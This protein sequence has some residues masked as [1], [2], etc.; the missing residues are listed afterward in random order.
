MRI[1]I[2]VDGSVEPQIYPINKPKLT[3]GSGETCDIVISSD[4]ISRKH[5][6]IINEGDAYYV[7]DQGSTN[8]TYINEERLVPGRR[9]EF[10]SFFPVRLGDQVLITL[11]SDDDPGASDEEPLIPLYPKE[12]TVT[13]VRSRGAEETTKMIS[14]S[15]LKKAKTS[16]LVT[17]REKAVQKKKTVTKKAPVKS[18]RAKETERFKFLQWVILG[19]LVAIGYYNVKTKSDEKSPEIASMGEIVPVTDAGPAAQAPAEPGPGPS[20]DEARV[21]PESELLDHSKYTQLLNDIK[22]VTDIEKYFCEKVP[23]TSG[24]R[25]GVVQIGTTIHLLLDG[26]TWIKEARSFI[27]YPQGT[28]TPEM[29]QIYQRT[30]FKAATALFYLNGF[31]ADIEWDKIKDMKIA[32]AMHEIWEGQTYLKMISEIYPDQIQNF[33]R[34]AD[35]ESIK[36]SGKE[37]EAALLYTDQFYRVKP[38]L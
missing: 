9:T 15:D 33:K 6:I 10:T 16:D 27:S 36:R 34:I 23:G 26:E 21:V 8:G 22:C 30:V 13:P 2:L 28:V 1:E 7:V 29:D 17:K 24:G 32:V 19:V 14:L 12:E 31:P 35:L 20:K 25:F 37:G 4:N 18:A 38:T 11:L 3:L 5:A